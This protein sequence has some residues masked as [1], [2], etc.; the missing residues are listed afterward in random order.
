VIELLQTCAEILQSISRAARGFSRDEAVIFAHN[1][2][3]FDLRSGIVNA[4]S[5]LALKRMPKFEENALDK[6]LLGK[7]EMDI[8]NVQGSALSRRCVDCK[9]LSRC[10]V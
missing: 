6:R 1:R 10:F 5:E 2:T 7:A 4:E 9:S 3:I 8:S